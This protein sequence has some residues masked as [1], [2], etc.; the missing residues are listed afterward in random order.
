MKEVPVYILSQVDS[1]PFSQMMHTKL[2]K[3]VKEVLVSADVSVKE[4]TPPQSPDHVNVYLLVS[5]DREAC[6]RLVEASPATFSIFCTP[7]THLVVGLAVRSVFPQRTIVLVSQN[8]KKTVSSIVTAVSALWGLSLNVENDRDASYYLE[9]CRKCG[10]NVSLKRPGEVVV[11]ECYKDQG[12]SAALEVCENDFITGVLLNILH[13]VG[14]QS[15]SLIQMDVLSVE[16]EKSQLF[17][18]CS[19]SDLHQLQ[20]KICYAFNFNPLR[21]RINIFTGTVSKVENNETG[22][23]ITLTYDTVNLS[24]A[25]SSQFGQHL[26]IT[27][28]SMSSRLVDVLEALQIDVCLNGRMIEWEN[29]RK[30]P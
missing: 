11:S 13:R 10:L 6:E 21:Q 30:L 23:F 17:H 9:L 29:V 18:C 7:P 15:Q 22:W 8:H 4:D 28:Q 14:I 12:K 19:P 27:T 25:L 16:P 2:L 1:D 24:T 5:K 3:D 26:L 20:G